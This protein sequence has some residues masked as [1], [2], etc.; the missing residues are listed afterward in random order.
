MEHILRALPPKP[1]SAVTRYGITSIIVGLCFLAVIG[2]N[3]LSGTPSWYL[4]LPAVFVTSVLFDRGSGIYAAILSTVILYLQTRWPEVQDSS[5]RLIIGVVAFLVVALSFAIV[6][7][8]LRTAWD[9]TQAAERAK[10]LLLQEL[11]HRT[12]NNLAMAISVLSLQSR[13]KTNPETKGAL[14]KA[15]ARIHA[16][17]AAHEYFDPSR[18]NGLVEMRAYLEALCGYLGES[19]RDVRPIAIRVQSDEVY[20]KTERAIPIGLIVN[21]LVTNALKHAFPEGREGIIGVTLTNV[22]PSLNLI[23]HDN[24]VGCPASKEERIGSRLT[25]LLAQQ[26]EAKISWEDAAPG[27]RVSCVIPDVGHS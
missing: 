21:E 18:Q 13:S 17:A 14:E 23:V 19:L 12:K 11:G 15:I 9:K 24:G 27:C 3:A 10:E 16:I 1:K 26:L 5:P 7:E 8:A 6:S 4:M 2:L 20:L 25:R 22:P